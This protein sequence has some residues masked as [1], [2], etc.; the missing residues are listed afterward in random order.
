M[1]HSTR[2]CVRKQ[3]SWHHTPC[4]PSLSAQPADS[5]PS[6]RTQAP[7][8]TAHSFQGPAHESQRTRK[9]RG[10]GDPPPPHLSMGPRL[11]VLRAYPE[12]LQKVPPGPQSALQGSIRW[13][14]MSWGQA[15]LTNMQTQQSPSL[16]QP[17]IWDDMGLH[18]LICKMGVVDPV[19]GFAY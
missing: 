12:S 9:T 8:L 11:A 4:Q 6:A 5:E 10:S 16:T 3:G 13:V 15:W 14:L 1:P 2:A 17:G 7:S 19:L 18:F